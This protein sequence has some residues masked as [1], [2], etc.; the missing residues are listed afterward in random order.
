[1]ERRCRPAGSDGIKIAVARLRTISALTF[2]A[3]SAGGQAPP[4]IRLD[5]PVAT[6]PAEWTSVIRVREL[7]D[8]RVLVLDLRDQVVKLADFTAGTALRVGAKGNGP[9]EYVMPTGLQPLPGDRTILFDDANS[10]RPLLIGPDGKPAGVFAL[11]RGPGPM[12]VGVGTEVDGLGRLY[13]ESPA[14]DANGVSPILR[15]TPATGKVDTVGYTSRKATACAPAAASSSPA[16]ERTSRAAPVGAQ[17]FVA[18]E[19]WTVAPDGRVALVCPKPYRV[20]F[21]S[22]M[23][24]R[25]D[26]PVIPHSPIKVTAAEQQAWR[27]ARN[28]PVAVVSFS[29]NGEKSAGFRKVPVPEP[30]EW[31]AVLPPFTLPHAF[32]RAVMFAPDGM[33]WIDR[34]VAAGSPAAYDVVGPDAKLAYRVTLPLRSRIVGFGASGIYVVVTDDDDIQR[35]Q[36]F[37]FPAMNNR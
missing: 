13:R 28:E 20:S 27:D 34:E 24:K 5:K 9:G 12:F 29:A 1:M 31:P 18:I 23:G 11:P 21:V 32:R 10:G 6:H 36:R 30:A 16:G 15:V 14:S 26:G 4:T 33:L 35:L 22:T 3:S 2:A 7:R 37:R 19:Q 17:P 8:G 25:L